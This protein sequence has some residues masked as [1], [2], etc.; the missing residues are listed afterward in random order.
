MAQS[1]RYTHVPTRSPSWAVALL[2]V[3]RVILCRC[4]KD[5]GI[6]VRQVA[7][8][9]GVSERKVREV[10]QH[11]R[12]EGY[13]ICGHPSTGYYMATTDEELNRTCEFLHARAMTSLQQ[14]AAMKR[15]PVPE[16]RQQLDLPMK[17]LD[18]RDYDEAEAGNAEA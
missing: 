15:K 14:I 2:R 8:A 6:T 17:G 9:A 18:V 4:G 11:L 13:Q 1:M 16:L 3:R 12:G 5:A 7:A 10:I